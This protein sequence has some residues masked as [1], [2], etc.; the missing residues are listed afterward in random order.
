MRMVEKLSVIP[1]TS[2]KAAT[3]HG[4][5]DAG[6]PRPY[7]GYKGD[8]NHCIEIWRNDKGRWESTVISTFDAYDIVRV[9]GLQRLR[10]HRLAQNG[11]PLVMRLM[12]DDVVRI[13]LDGVIRAMRVATLSKNGQVFMADLHEANVDARNRAPES[14]FKYTSKKAGSLM[15]AQARRV[16]VS[17]TG[18][19]RD[20]GFK[21]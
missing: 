7:K 3:R 18:D 11:R 17:V 6:A 2:K 19:L 4:L 14:E 15:S 13:E 12:I 1:I 10:H 21:P 20:P 5:D 9:Y 16:T 8:S